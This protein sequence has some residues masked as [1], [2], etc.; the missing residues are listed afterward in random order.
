MPKHGAVL[1]PGMGGVAWRLDVWS[2][3]VVS[4]GEA[5][6]L[7]CTEVTAGEVA[8]RGRGQSAGCTGLGPRPVTRARQAW[9]LGPKGRPERS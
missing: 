9:L 8:A 1:D 4:A 6:T 2:H 5:R 7:S 3:G